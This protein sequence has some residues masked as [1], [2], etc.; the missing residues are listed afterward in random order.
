MSTLHQWQLV[1]DIALALSLLVAAICFARKNTDSSN[2]QTRALEESL[3]RLLD[4]ADTASRSLATELTRRQNGLERLLLDLESGEARISRAL[5]SA[6]SVAGTLASQVTE[7]LAKPTRPL[8]KQIEVEA[9]L[10]E[11]VRLSREVAAPTRLEPESLAPTS[12]LNIFGDPIQAPPVRSAKAIRNYAAAPSSSFRTAAPQ[13][14]EPIREDIEA[15]YNAAE[16]MLRAG[17]ELNEIQRATKI[18]R[19]DLDML[20]EVVHREMRMEKRVPTAEKKSEVQ[21][22]SRLGVLSPARIRREVQTL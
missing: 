15:I 7:A 2:Q 20:S 12:G 22:D 13:S 14:G 16:A 4:E 10:A 1:C 11:P 19:A 3:R 17:K 9:E 5:T 6:D 18:P 8:A 21:A